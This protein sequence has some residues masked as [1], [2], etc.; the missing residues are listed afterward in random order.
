MRPSRPVPTALWPI[1]D[2]LWAC[3]PSQKTQLKSLQRDTH[4]DRSRQSRG[5]FLASPS[6]S[7]FFIPNL[8]FFLYAMRA[9]FLAALLLL[10]GWSTAVPQQPVSVHLDS[11]RTFHG[12]VDPRTDDVQ[13][14]LRCTYGRAVIL[15]PI[16]WSRVAQAE[17]AGVT[18]TADRFRE[19]VAQLRQET[20]GRF[21]PD[22]PGRALWQLV[23]AFPPLPCFPVVRSLEAA[24]QLSNWDGDA[25]ADGYTLRVMPLG[26]DESLLPVE[27]TLEATLHG[28]EITPRE[29]LERWSQLAN[30][31]QP[32]TIDCYGPAGGVLRLPYCAVPNELAYRGSPRRVLR[33]RLNAPGHG[34]FEAEIAFLA[35]RPLPH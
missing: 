32:V 18:E 23:P 24:V 28:Y 3:T 15:R 13:L 11:G 21:W 22:E 12:L 30:W 4:I 26:G 29:P 10:A 7:Q 1:R 19:R 9:L 27:G 6:D 34:T 17:V 35:A 25:E 5:A 8:L 16:E 31:S 33:L 20:P 14:W 2:I